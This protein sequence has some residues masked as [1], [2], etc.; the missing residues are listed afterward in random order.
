MA[1]VT[2]RDIAERCNLSRAS[3]SLVIQDSPRVSD[4]TKVRVRQVMAQMGY[5]YDRRAANLRGGRTFGL[6]L[7]LTDVH[8]PAL[9][10]LAMAVEDGAAEAGCSV[11]MGYSRDD[12]GR[13]SRTIQAMLECR[14]DGIILSP[15][16]GTKPE[17]FAQLGQSGIPV[18]QVTRRV[19]GLQS[20]YA[21]PNNVMAGSLLADHLADLGMRSVAFLGGSR[22]VSARQERIQ[23]FRNQ[24]RKRGLIWDPELAIA[25]NALESGGLLG[26][27]RLL[28]LRSGALPDAIIAYSDIVA[29]G[30]IVELRSRGFNVGA[31]VAVAGIDDSPT[32]TLLHPSLT[33][34][35]TRMTAVGNEAVRLV[36]ARIEKSGHDPVSTFVDSKLHIRDSTAS[37]ARSPTSSGC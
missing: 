4:A 17:T 27:R 24:W 33:S 29:A 3:I 37:W 31:D 9:A 26:V 6:G 34:V 2:L 10:D 23:G 30:A 25:T 1:A 22:G 12:V 8:N 36:L 28:D 11:M 13:Q 15:A 35:E 32:A 21:G 18:V 19:K 14:L 7:I 20:D 5:V 16:Q